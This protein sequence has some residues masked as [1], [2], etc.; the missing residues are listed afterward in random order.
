MSY[1]QEPSELSVQQVQA[2]YSSAM[3]GTGPWLVSALLSARRQSYPAAVE[4]MGSY[5]RIFLALCEPKVTYCGADMEHR[6]RGVHP[7]LFPWSRHLLSH[8]FL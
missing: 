7:F 6:R 2:L 1:G 3:L 4:P 8:K 5:T